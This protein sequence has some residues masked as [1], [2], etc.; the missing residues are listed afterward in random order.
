MA[1]ERSSVAEGGLIIQDFLPE[2]KGSHLAD[3]IVDGLMKEPKE[4]PSMFFYDERGS[5]LYEMITELPEYYPPQVETKLIAVAADSLAQGLRGHDIV[6]LGS[7]D[8][9]KISILL[10]RVPPADIP[11]LRYVPV[12][13][14]RSAVEESAANLRTRF[15]GMDIHGIVGDFLSHLDCMPDGRD[16]LLAF[17][18]STIG[19]LEKEKA[20]GFFQELKEVLRP[21][22]E[23]LLGLDMVKDVTVMERAYNDSQGVTAEFNLNIVNV[24]NRLIGSHLDP[25]SFEHLAFF[26]PNESRIEMHL[27]A[28]SPMSIELDGLEAPITIE[29]G[30]TIHTENSYK[31]TMERIERL[32]GSAGLA[33]RERYTDE[34]GWFSLLRLGN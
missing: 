22:D 2:L 10:D 17:F 18:G 3:S 21:G 7:G 32:V 11:T 4:I 25:N 24:V 23:M 30:E 9:S 31:F 26:N 8:C 16:R 19:N 5:K 6:E 34:N 14:S 12:D 1:S 29:E 27:R 28:I 33:I 20:H 15:P 13:F